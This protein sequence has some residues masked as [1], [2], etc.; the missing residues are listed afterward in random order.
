MYFIRSALLKRYFYVGRRVYATKYLD[1]RFPNI[2]TTSVSARKIAE[3]LLQDIP[4]IDA[5]N[6][7]KA[8]K[9]WL[10]LNDRHD[11]VVK[12]KTTETALPVPYSTSSDGG[13]QKGGSL[14]PVR[15]EPG[16]V[17]LGMIP[18]EWVQYFYGTT[19]VT[20]F[21]TF[22][23]TYGT[24][25]I[26]KEKLVMEHEYY[27]A[28]ATVVFWVLAAKFVGPSLGKS[29]DKEVDKYESDMNHNR[30]MEVKFANESIAM[31]EKNQLSMEGHL[32]LMDAKREN[33]ALQLEL[34][35]RQRQMMVYRETLRR[36]EFQ[37]VK[38]YIERRIAHHNI[39]EWVVREVKKSITPDYDKIYQNECID[40]LTKLAEKNKR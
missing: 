9:K 20:G 25:L 35:F 34:A 39:M 40:N 38:Q 17:H 32:M 29:L 28:L 8:V 14:R 1:N 18:V 3:N 5:R 11:E 36:L 33:V 26:S 22:C 13:E 21:Y 12:P 10:I 6:L 7:F 24:Y 4:E 23:F 31:E 37:V 27:T 16:K 2:R 30:T 19:G 15:G